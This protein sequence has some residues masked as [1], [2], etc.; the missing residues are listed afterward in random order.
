MTHEIAIVELPRLPNG[1]QYAICLTCPARTFVEDKYFCDPRKFGK[2]Y[3]N[4]VYRSRPLNCPIQR[5][6]QDSSLEAISL[7]KAM[8]RRK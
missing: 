1:E 8:L 6:S 3:V 4:K 2:D 5:G 7:L